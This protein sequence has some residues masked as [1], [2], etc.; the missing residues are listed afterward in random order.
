MKDIELY[1]SVKGGLG[2]FKD[3]DDEKRSE[4]SNSE[5][6]I[7]VDTGFNLSAAFGEIKGP[8]RGEI[9]II[10]QKNDFEATVSNRIFK[11]NF[12][13]AIEAMRWYQMYGDGDIER[14]DITEG[15]ISTLS[16]MANIYHDFE[17]FKHI[18]PYIGLGAGILNIDISEISIDTND[19]E[20]AFG[21]QS[22]S[23]FAWQTMLGVGYG[24]SK[25]L[26][27]DM[28]YRF[29]WGMN[30]DFREMSGIEIKNH[31]FTL[32]LRYLF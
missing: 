29:F 9:E 7:S 27:I 26:L 20:P 13:S 18:K 22:D 23:V 5:I 1:A 6:D 21:K 2:Y 12:T 17:L 15:T 14:S 25:N 8:W 10:Y 16:L 24:I 3:I 11:P 32:G 30:P 19:P 28:A 31:S 4:D